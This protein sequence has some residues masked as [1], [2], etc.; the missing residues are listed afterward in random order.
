MYSTKTGCRDKLKAFTGNRRLQKYLFLDLWRQ[1]LYGKEK[2]L[3]TS[4]GIEGFSLGTHG[5][6]FFRRGPFNRAGQ[7][8]DAKV[9]NQEQRKRHIRLQQLA[10]SF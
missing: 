10:A 8:Y 7:I 3:L 1:E 2:Q 9:A 4:L 6:H 5:E